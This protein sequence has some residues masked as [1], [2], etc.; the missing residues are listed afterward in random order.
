MNKDNL[1][2]VSHKLHIVNRETKDKYVKGGFPVLT[3]EISRFFDKV[4][5]CVPVKYDNSINSNISYSQNINIENINLG[6]SLL[7]K[8]KKLVEIANVIK[9][10]QGIVYAMAPNVTGIVG[11][12]WAY[13]FKRPYF[14]S[15]DTDKAEVVRLKARNKI[16]GHLKSKLIEI[17]HYGIIKI[18]ARNRP[19][20][21]TGNMFL[22]KNKNWYQWVKSTDK[23]SDIRPYK[24]PSKVKSN[25]SFK[26]IY[27]GR[28]SPE[29]N[30][31]VLLKALNKLSYKKYS[32]DIVGEGSEYKKLKEIVKSLS[33]SNVEFKGYID[34]KVLKESRFLKADLLVLPSRSERQGKVLLEA[35]ASSIPVLASNTEGIS[36][37]IH[38]GENGLLFNPNSPKE[39]SN[40]IKEISDNYMLRKKVAKNGHEFSKKHAVDEEIKK[41]IN[42]VFDFYE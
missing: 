42:T 34:N 26:I 9:E 20:F 24:V 2:I 35:M 29:K 16:L 5:L 11:M 25:S 1:I 21:I 31:E 13:L 15:V 41:I 36:S 22:G 7:G 39:L 27:V 37:I 18:L 3:N 23:L 12:V 19:L 28:L 10:N 33:L 30:I 32:L 14:V 38:D 4:I 6:N 40:R 8:A 17:L